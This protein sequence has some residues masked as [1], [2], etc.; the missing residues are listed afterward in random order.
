MQTYPNSPVPAWTYP[1][2]QAFNTLISNFDSGAEQRRQLLRFSKRLF[3]L[4]YKNLILSERNTLHD[5]YRQVYGS[6]SSFW[7][8][9]WTSRRWVDEYVGRG[10]LNVMTGAVAAVHPD[11][12]DANR[13]DET[14]A[15]NNTTANDMTLMQASPAINDSYY[16]GFVTTPWDVLR[17]NIG[18]AGAGTWTIAWEYYNGAW[19]SLA[20]VTD[21]SNGFK[22]SGTVDVLWNQPTDMALTT[23]K[24]ISAYWVRAR[25]SAFT[26]I[27]TQAKGTQ[28]WAASRYYDLH[29]LTTNPY[30][31]YVDGVQKTGGGTDY[32]FISGGGGAN[33]DG[34]KFVA[35]PN[36]G[37]LITSDVT[38]YLR[39]KGRLGDDTFN[40][41]TIAPG[42]FNVNIKVQ[43]VQW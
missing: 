24:S 18:T 23:I 8:V 19:V 2:G 10:V 4:G 33:A 11:S 30:V 9:D 29:C 41:E 26:S 40:E 31:I 12:S 16:F 3:T 43:E 13:T 27:T 42:I 28:S 35:M 25:V 36:I 5:F 7:Y 15:A 1:T 6:A 14:S 20:S 38:G 21:G 37:S 22:N 34:I 39:I 32:T 17:L